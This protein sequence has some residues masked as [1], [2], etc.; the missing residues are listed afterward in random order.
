MTNAFFVFNKRQL[1]LRG[2]YSLRSA[3]LY[4]AIART[5]DAQCNSFKWIRMSSE[6]P[7]ELLRRM[8]RRSVLRPRCTTFLLFRLA[9]SKSNGRIIQKIT[10]NWFCHVSRELWTIVSISR[11]VCWSSQDWS[12]LTRKQRC[13]NFQKWDHPSSTREK[14]KRKKNPKIAILGT[15]LLGMQ[16]VETL[17]PHL[18]YSGE[19][20]TT[21]IWAT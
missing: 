8:P 18:Y 11:F 16:I 7:P 20:V 14:D 6:M 4:I 15:L 21:R 2:H 9:Q 12:V 19:N 17:F 3:A 1:L 10:N 13:C 5:L